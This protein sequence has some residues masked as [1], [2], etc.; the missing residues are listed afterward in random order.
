MAR[1]S[2]STCSIRAARGR[3]DLYL[4]RGKKLQA[5]DGLVTNFHL[6]KSSLLLLV[7]A[8]GGTERIMAAY[9]HALE[10]GYRFYSYGDAM[11][12]WP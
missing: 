5:I 12:V 7:C 11:L 2:W 9:R 10:H 1:T 4:Y 8:F 3:T 6:P